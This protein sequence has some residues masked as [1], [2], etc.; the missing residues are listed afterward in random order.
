MAIEGRVY[1]QLTGRPIEG[2]IIRYVVVHSYFPEIYAG[3]PDEVVSDNQGKFILQ[4]TV[5][6]TDNIKIVVEA[7]G[8]KPFE[9]RLD[10]LGDRMMNIGLTP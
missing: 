8:Y 3:K 6:D 9:Q 5:H 7:K 2:A 10:L 4:M 1:D